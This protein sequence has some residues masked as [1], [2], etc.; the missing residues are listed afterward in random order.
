V[1][2]A[3]VRNAIFELGSALHA[4]RASSILEGRGGVF[5]LSD[6]LGNCLP[7]K[8]SS[9]AWTAYLDVEGRA[10]SVAG[11]TLPAGLLLQASRPRLTFWPDARAASPGTLTIC[12]SRRIA[13]PRAIVLS[14]TG[15]IRAGVAH[16][17]DCAP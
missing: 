7:G 3:A 14:Q 2:E 6:A 15:R 1:R 17:S 4:T 9:N 12:D 8:D 10:Q 11:Q 13:R 5:C 16:E